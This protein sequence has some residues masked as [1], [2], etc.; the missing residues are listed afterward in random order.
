MEQIMFGSNKAEM[1]ALAP[2]TGLTEFEQGSCSY[3][4]VSGKEN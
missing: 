4:G 2:M 3:N 1:T